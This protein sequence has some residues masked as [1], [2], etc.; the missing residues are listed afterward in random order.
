MLLISF[1]QV[2][3]FLIAFLSLKQAKNEGKL[4][5]V[6]EKARLKLNYTNNPS[7][8]RVSKSFPN[9]SS[10]QG[11]ESDNEFNIQQFCNPLRIA[12]EGISQALRNGE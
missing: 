2:L 8:E 5:I 10:M 3:M 9:Q 11:G 7:F 4:G 6:H 12:Q 1:W